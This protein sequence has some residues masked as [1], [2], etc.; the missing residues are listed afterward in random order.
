MPYNIIPDLFTN[1]RIRRIPSQ[2]EYIN[3]YSKI[4][5]N[6][7]HGSHIVNSYKII[8]DGLISTKQII[9]NIIP[10]RLAINAVWMSPNTWQY[11]R[12]IYGNIHFLFH[13]NVYFENKNIYW[14]GIKSTTPISC[15]F[16]ITDKD[17]DGD[18][19]NYDIQISDGPLRFVPERNEYYYNKSYNIEL[20]FD[21]EFSLT[22]LIGHEIRSHHP[23]YCNLK[24]KTCFDKLID[25]ANTRFVLYSNL[26]LFSS[27]QNLN[28]LY[29]GTLNKDFSIFIN[30]L[31]AIGFNAI[32]PNR[33][34]NSDSRKN[35]L[36]RLFFLFLNNLNFKDARLILSEFSSYDEYKIALFLFISSKFNIPNFDLSNLI[37][38]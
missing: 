9:D 10:R 3:D 16:L 37:D 17:Y 21:I 12:S 22:E 13:H 6:I 28:L 7:S 25:K 15:I 18:F 24:L 14:L 27:L 26:I 38:D 23:D 5:A 30:R 36:L 33:N 32:H 20:M 31:L 34:Y 4:I 2:G 19:D 29:D 1:Y 8:Y 11:D 35:L